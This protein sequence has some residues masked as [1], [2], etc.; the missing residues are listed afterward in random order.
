VLGL[1]PPDYSCT[2]APVLGSTWTS[3][4]ATTPLMGVST[5]ATLVVFG[6]GGP[7]Q[8]AAVRGFELLVLPPFD[9]IDPSTTG[10][11]AIPI[12]SDPALSGL[13]VATQGVRV[14]VSP[15]GK[16]VFVLTNAQDLVLGT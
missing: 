5:A 15:A 12:P 14:E 13:S 3:A 1:D 6:M 2:S 7:V 10:A 11:H 4:I 8:G 9:P 16:P